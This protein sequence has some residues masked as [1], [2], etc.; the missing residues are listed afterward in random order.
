MS[1]ARFCLLPSYFSLR[2]KIIPLKRKTSSFS[3]GRETSQMR[4]GEGSGEIM[5]SGATG[6]LLPLLQRT[7]NIAKRWTN[8]IPFKI[9][10]SMDP[11]AAISMFPSSSGGDDGISQSIGDFSAAISRSAAAFRESDVAW[12][13]MSAP[14]M[15]FRQN[16]LLDV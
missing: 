3:R 10:R 7:A 14:I 1:E 13:L 4:H 6:W 9:S 15:I 11:A 16:S 8:I 12:S 5:P 2:T